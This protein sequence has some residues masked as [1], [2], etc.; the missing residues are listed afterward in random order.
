MAQEI[1]D[2]RKIILNAAREG[3]ARKGFYGTSMD[4]IVKRTGLSKGAIYWY[5]PGKWEMYKAVISEEAER[6]KNIVIPQNLEALGCDGAAFFVTKG[7]RLIDS[8]A[9]DPLC[10]LLFVH[11]TLE[12]MRG[13]EEMVEFVTTLRSSIT[14]DVVGVFQA[15]FPADSLEEDGISHKEIVNMFVSILHGLIMNL[16]LTV[17]REEAKKNW[18]FLSQRVL[19]GVIHGT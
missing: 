10:R 11:L 16:E 12:A 3:F 7:E 13:R 19:G 1:R 14:E 18:R 8:L 4:F 5:F 6:I 15:L 9:D 17:S 2:S